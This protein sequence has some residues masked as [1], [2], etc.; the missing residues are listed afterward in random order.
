ML[1]SLLRR[2]KDLSLSIDRLRAIVI[3]QAAR[4]LYREFES[5]SL[6]HAVW[7]AEKIGCIPL[8]IAGNR[9]SD[10]TFQQRRQ[11]VFSAGHVRSPVFND[12]IRRT[13]CDH[14]PIIRRR[15]FDWYART[16]S[17]VPKLS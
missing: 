14:K 17:A 8:K 1:I 7:D 4:K 16:M 15:R 2:V 11:T 12:S 6:R 13:Q 9:R 10:L 5:L 3:N